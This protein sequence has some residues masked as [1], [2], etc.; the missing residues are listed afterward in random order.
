MLNFSLVSVVQEVA[1]ENKNFAPTGGGGGGVGGGWSYQP[2]EF[3]DDF[4]SI[5]RGQHCVTGTV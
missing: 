4:F 5:W 1:L 3:L 2:F